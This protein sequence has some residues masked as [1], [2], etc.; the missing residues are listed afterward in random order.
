MFVDVARAMA[1]G[2]GG[3][4]MPPNKGETCGG[5]VKTHRRP[6]DRSVTT[7][8]V[9][10]SAAFMGIIAGM[11]ANTGPSQSFPSLPSMAGHTGDR[12]MRACKRKSRLGV[13]IALDRLPC[14]RD[15]TGL[16]RPAQLPAMRIFAG[17][18]GG[19]IPGQAAIIIACPVAGGAG[20]A[21]VRTRQRIVAQRVVE[22]G[23]VQTDQRKAPPLVIAVA[24]FT[25]AGP[26]GSEF[27]VIARASGNVRSDT[28]VAG[29]TFSVLRCL[30]EGA[31]ASIALGFELG[32]GARQRPRRNQTLDD[33]LG[34][35]RRRKKRENQPDKTQR[36][37]HQYMCTA[38]I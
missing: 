10:S 26:R 30:L 32:M 8:A 14:R 12:T 6:G 27:A 38:T 17:M 2:A 31:V 9:C 25:R 16:A 29:D 1:G 13:V 19:A 33:A 20:G 37:A 23:A 34:A 22:I 5:M 35:D 15:M 24:S 18:A 36:F 3:R 11:A 4:R 7:G 21:L 28:L